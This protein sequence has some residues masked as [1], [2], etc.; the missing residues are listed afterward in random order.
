MCSSVLVDPARYV[1][2]LGLGSL[3]K[4]VREAG[5]VKTSSHRD[6][7]AD[8]GRGAEPLRAFTDSK[9]ANSAVKTQW[10]CNVPTSLNFSSRVLGRTADKAKMRAK[11]R[12]V[13]DSRVVDP[14]KV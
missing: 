3:L 11:A 2:Q 9:A 14:E 12:I 5:T 7:L 10:T 13:D 1:V 4:M 8:A 6:V